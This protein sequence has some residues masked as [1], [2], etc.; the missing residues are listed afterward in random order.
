M[1]MYFHGY[2]CT[3]VFGRYVD[4]GNPSIRLVADAPNGECGLMNGEPIA[5]ATLNCAK[6]DLGL[7]A[8]KGYSE[9]AGM[10]AALIAAGVIEPGMS[11]ARDTFLGS[12][13]IYQ[14]S[15][16]S[17]VMLA[18]SELNGREVAA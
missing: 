15:E 18:Q 17:M 5:T 14:L 1:K 13:A 7:V 6:L 8:I 11:L 9:N 4:S 3:V 10:E 16:A 2:P 12:I